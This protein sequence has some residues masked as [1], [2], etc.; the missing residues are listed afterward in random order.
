MFEWDEE[1]AKLN[2]IKHCVGF[3]FTTRAFDDAQRIT[4]LDH[5]QDYKENRYITLAKI[6]NRVYVVT[7]TLRSPKIR[8]ISAR[9]ANTREVN[10]YENR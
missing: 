10:R 4:V 6:D 3:E 1:K 9:K 5:R 7:F 8:L 2:Q